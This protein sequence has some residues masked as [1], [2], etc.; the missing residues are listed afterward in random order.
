VNGPLEPPPRGRRGLPVRR[1]ATRRR[2]FPARR[3][4]RLTALFEA[5][6]VS[7]AN[8]GCSVDVHTLAVERSRLLA[9]IDPVVASTM[10]PMAVD[11]VDRSAI[12]ERRRVRVDVSRDVS[13]LDVVGFSVSETADGTYREH[14]GETQRSRPAEPPRRSAGSRGAGYVEGLL[15]STTHTPMTSKRRAAPQRR[16]FRGFACPPVGRTAHHATRGANERSVECR[17]DPCGI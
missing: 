1:G 9:V 7:A 8:G 15:S 5:P 10:I 12:V 17:H 13:R 14:P 11:P 4:R 6:V 16:N 3:R 2:R